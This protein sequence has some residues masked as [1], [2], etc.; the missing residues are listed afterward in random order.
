MFLCF[1][2]IIGRMGR[3]RLVLP[4]KRNGGDHVG[5]VDKWI[6][7]LDFQFEI[8]PSECIRHKSPKSTCDTC[9]TVCPEDA[10]VLS[11]GKPMID[12]QKCNECGACMTACPVQAVS[13]ILPKKRFF[14]SKLVALANAELPSVKELLIFYAKGITAIACREKDFSS[15]WQERINEVNSILAQLGKA[16]FVMETEASFEDS[17]SRRELFSMWKKE[18]QSLVKQVTPAKWRF[19]HTDLDVNRYYPDHQ[20]FDVAID[21]D[22]C[23]LCQVCKILCPKTCFKIEDNHFSI[24]LQPCT[25]CDLC[26]EACPEKAVTIT[27]LI[28]PAEVNSF[29]IFQRTCSSCKDSFQ[30]LHEEDQKCPVCASMKA[31]YLSSRIC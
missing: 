30:T 26:R 5:F 27:G 14:H 21:A 8:I 28:A 13:G 24:D 23:T 7:S 3:G 1:R 29:G 6:E 15:P 31:G 16:A 17:F 18:S 4:F 19:N 2:F 22:K 12:Q 10:I 9:L 20:F 25:G 11:G